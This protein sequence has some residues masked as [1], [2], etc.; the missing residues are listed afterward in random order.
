[1]IKRDDHHAAPSA[2]P[3]SA[4]L[5]AGAGISEAVLEAGTISPILSRDRA[6]VAGSIDAATGDRILHD[7]MRAA[8]PGEIL[9]VDLT[10]VDRIDEAGLEILYA[11]QRQARMIGGELMLAGVPERFRDLLGEFTTEDDLPHR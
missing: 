7:L 10:A 6:E 11:A 4:E 8:R 2:D 5:P 9:R 3:D 1:M